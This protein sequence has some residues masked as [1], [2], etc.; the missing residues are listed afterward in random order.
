MCSFDGRTTAGKGRR[1]RG[2]ATFPALHLPGILRRTTKNLSEDSL[3]P[4]GDSKWKLSE[5]NI[6]GGILY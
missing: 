2:F 5:Y 6:S 1:C 4:I 3:C